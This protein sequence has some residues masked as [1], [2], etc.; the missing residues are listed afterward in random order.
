MAVSWRDLFKIDT[1]K[2][3]PFVRET[4]QELGSQYLPS[5]I[6]RNCRPSDLVCK[7]TDNYSLES[8]VPSA[9]LSVT[10]FVV[11]HPIF[12]AG[13]GAGV[14]AGGLYYLYR[15]RHP[16]KKQAPQ[17][18]AQHALPPSFAAHSIAAS[19]GY[20]PHNS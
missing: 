5:I 6:K 12:C 3:L 20:K 4:A 2:V 19:L 10:D 15:H 14:A 17:T 9:V 18:N 13:A 11:N 1:D 7:V 16:E 8:F